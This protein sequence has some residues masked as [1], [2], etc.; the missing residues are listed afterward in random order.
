MVS[1]GLEPETTGL[2]L[3]GRPLTKRKEMKRKGKE[4]KWSFNAS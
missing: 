3:Y 2:R 1:E 4:K